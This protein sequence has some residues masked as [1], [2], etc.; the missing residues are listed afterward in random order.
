M[1]RVRALWVLIAFA[2]LALATLILTQGGGLAPEKKD[3]KKDDKKPQKGYPGAVTIEE[4]GKILE[5]LGYDVELKERAEK[6][7]GNQYLVKATDLSFYASLS[8]NKE[9]IWF[10]ASLV[11]V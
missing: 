2:G 3:D 1:R 8:F 9:V 10:Q 5:D 4:F 7:G 6:D 11:N